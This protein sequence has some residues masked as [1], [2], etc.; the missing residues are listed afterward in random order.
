MDLTPVANMEAS[1]SEM[2]WGRALYQ[3]QPISMRCNYSGLPWRVELGCAVVAVLHCRLPNLRQ[4]TTINP[5]NAETPCQIPLLTIN[6]VSPL[7]PCRACIRS[8]HEPL[9]RAR[10]SFGDGHHSGSF[11]RSSTGPLILHAMPSLITS[12]LIL[13]VRPSSLFSD[14]L[15]F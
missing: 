6:F 9:P 13:P 14:Y 8:V 15:G 3:P 4:P 12:C 10:G 11:L 7:L 5:L 1:W 2:E